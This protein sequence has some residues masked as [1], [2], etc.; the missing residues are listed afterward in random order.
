[1]P[2]TSNTTKARRL[3]ACTLVAALAVTVG[4]GT[5]AA[6]PSASVQKA[7]LAPTKTYLLKHTTKLR[8]FT[9]SFRAQANRYFA[10]AEST[11]FDYAALWKTERAAVAPVLRRSKALWIEG[12]PYYERVEGLVA[13]TPSLAV[14]DVIL[15]AGTSC[16]MPPC[17]EQ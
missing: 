10:L 1:M 8:G 5:S 16:G 3:G 14:Y 13:G 4:A 17:E 6:A 7:N 9:S 12:N 11:S 15:D 2:T